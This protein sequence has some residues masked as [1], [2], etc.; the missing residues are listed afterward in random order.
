MK[1]N[2][3]IVVAFDGREKVDNFYCLPPSFTFSEKDT[4][5]TVITHDSP[6]TMVNNDIVNRNYDVLLQEMYW[7]K[8]KIDVPVTITE[9]HH[10]VP[11]TRYSKIVQQTMIYEAMMTM[12]GISFNYPKFFYRDSKTITV[13]YFNHV[14][15]LE[16]DAKYIIK[17]CNGARSIGI[18]EIYG[19]DFNRFNLA[20]RDTPDLDELINKI[21]EFALSHTLDAEGVNYLREKFMVMKKVENIKEEYRLL[22]SDYKIVNIQRRHRIPSD[23]GFTYAKNSEAV[24]K[25]HF[26]AAQIN[27]L[28]SLIKQIGI[29]FGS[30]DLYQTADGRFGIFEFQNQFGIESYDHKVVENIHI[31]YIK[32][33]LRRKKLI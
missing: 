32:T 16:N 33:V 5:V 24:D 17:P 28:N 23:S 19:K 15:A 8:D 26:P 3:T 12:R 22:V 31:D 9:K 7:D 30:V 20:I 21:K 14:P 25:K 13:K 11:M 1:K 29:D 18:V 6:N 2:K 4:E 27:L 10:V